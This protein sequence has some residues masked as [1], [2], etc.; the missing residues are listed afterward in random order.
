[1]IT[2][3]IHIHGENGSGGNPSRHQAVILLLPHRTL[4]AR[5]PC[6]CEEKVAVGLL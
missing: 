3:M 5:S 1:M 6:G 2:I 4:T